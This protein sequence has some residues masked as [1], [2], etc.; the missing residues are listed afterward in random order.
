MYRSTRKHTRIFQ[1]HLTACKNKNSELISDRKDV[2]NIW[3]NHF[4]DLLNSNEVEA[5]SDT[6]WTVEN[7]LE[8]PILEDT[9]R[10]IEKLKSFKSCGEDSINVELIKY[11]REELHK[12]IHELP[13]MPEEWYTSLIVPIYK[14]GDKTNCANYRDKFG[15]KSGVRQG[16]S[17]SMLLFNLTLHAVINKIDEDGTIFYKFT[18][19]SAYADEVV[20]IARNKEYL[21]RVI[22]QLDQATKQTGLR[23][24][25]ERTKYMTRFP[26]DG[27][28]RIGSY[29]F[30][31]I[32]EFKYLGV[33]LSTSKDATFAL[34]DRIQTANI[35]YFAHMK[36]MKSTLLSK[37]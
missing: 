14:K 1:P 33:V 28:I 8:E 12:Q 11:A 5:P 10:A 36:L 9:K 21:Q 4:S 24:N 23:I 31:S 18:Q 17:L 16:D 30:E 25:E 3:K 34:Q 2:L 27:H 13:E 35:A 22:I 7:M 20:I 29:N 6:V 32:N 15:T 19:I 37:E 26:Q